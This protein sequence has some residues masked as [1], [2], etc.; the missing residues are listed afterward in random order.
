[1][2]Q[3]FLASGPDTPALRVGVIGHGAIGRPVVEALRGHDLPGATLSGVLTR[4]PGAVNEQLP[5]IGALVAASD[6]IVEAAGHQALHDHAAVVLEAGADLL[7]VSTGALADPALRHRLAG[8][9]PGR[10]WVCPGAIGGVDLLRA[11]S[12]AEP[13]LSVRLTSTKL[14]TS[15][16][17]PW[18]DDDQVTRLRSLRTGQL[19]VF[20]GRAEEAARSFPTNANVAA[21][22]ALATGN[23]DTV[24]VRL[25]ADATATATRHQI[26]FAGDIGQYHLDISNHPSPDNAASS[27]LVAHA[28]LRAIADRTAGAAFLF[29]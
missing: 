20:E 18:M 7:V 25:I 3:P 12:R 14:P 21:T 23:W 24:E 10:L 15:L 16:I 29:A 2:I 28:L 9:G 27:G 8:T 11:V 17:R 26:D 13:G 19:V 6:L 5:D 1:V 22:L 4:S